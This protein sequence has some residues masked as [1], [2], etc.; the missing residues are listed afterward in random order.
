MRKN[1]VKTLARKVQNHF[2]CSY[3]T[4]RRFVTE[5]LEEISEDT[6]NLIELAS[7][8]GLVKTYS[9]KLEETFLET[10]E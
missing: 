2:G 3:S 5:N 1:K 10:M 9:K 8:F 7:D 4:A 6:S